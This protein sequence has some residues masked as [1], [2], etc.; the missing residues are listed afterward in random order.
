M[1]IPDLGLTKEAYCYMLDLLSLQFKDDQ[2]SQEFWLLREKQA[3]VRQL[4]AA[5]DEEIK[6]S[7]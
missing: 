1:S 7:C 3:R 6:C 5:I 2:P 4:I